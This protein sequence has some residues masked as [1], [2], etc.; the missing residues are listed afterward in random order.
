MIWAKKKGLLLTCLTSIPALAVV[1][2][3]KGVVVG[4]IRGPEVRLQLGGPI[5]GRDSLSQAKYHD[6][7]VASLYCG[8]HL[9]FL[10]WQQLYWAF[11]RPF[12]GLGITSRAQAVLV[13]HN[14]S[15]FHPGMLLCPF[16]KCLCVFMCLCMCVW[17]FPSPGKLALGEAG[18]GAIP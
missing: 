16:A 12:C 17:V 1:W 18:Y 8:W 11:C 13:F 2:K 14:W 9:T 4:C 15:R 10:S 6:W 3:T 5:P 7:K